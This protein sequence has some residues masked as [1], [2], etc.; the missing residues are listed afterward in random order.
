ME[1]MYLDS[2]TLSNVS[3]FFHLGNEWNILWKYFQHEG[4]KSI[5][6]SYYYVNDDHQEKLANSHSEQVRKFNQMLNYWLSVFTYN[7]IVSIRSVVNGTELDLTN[8]DK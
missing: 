8:I 3:P 2:V 7:F 1:I 5:N 4:A 6:V